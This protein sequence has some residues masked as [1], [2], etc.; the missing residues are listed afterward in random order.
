MLNGIRLRGIVM[1]FPISNLYATFRLILKNSPITLSWNGN[2]FT[3]RYSIGFKIQNNVQRDS[4]WPIPKALLFTHLKFRW[5][6]SLIQTPGWK[7][8]PTMVRSY[9]L[10]GSSLRALRMRSLS[11]FDWNKILAAEPEQEFL[12]CEAIAV[13]SFS[14]QSPILLSKP[15]L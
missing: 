10:L 13:L 5:I 12:R 2:M 8:Y 11:A 3:R 1:K 14:L 4:P 6:L 7:S 15:G 9:C